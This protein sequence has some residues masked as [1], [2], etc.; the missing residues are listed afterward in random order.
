VSA[1]FAKP[2]ASETLVKQFP[3]LVKLRPAL[4]VA[5]D[6]LVAVQHH[7]GR[8]RRM[9]ADLDGQMAPVGVED[10]ERIVVDVGHRLFSLDVVLCADIPH[11]RLGSTN[12]D[13]KQA[14]LDRRFGQVFFGKV[15]LA[16]ACGTVDHRNAVSLGVAANPA[17][18]AAGH[19]HQVGVL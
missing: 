2:A 1:I 14:P 13:Q 3:S 12:Q 9:P 6:V 10:V 4:R 16:L 19:P 8:E 11:R 17:T 7:L 15:V 18:E 5:S